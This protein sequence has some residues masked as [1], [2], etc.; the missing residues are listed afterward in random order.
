MKKI[1]VVLLLF[2]I[3]FSVSAVGTSATSAILMDQDSGR[4]LYAS[5]IH[6]VRSVASIS[7]V[8]TALLAV[9][10]GKLK[11]KV[12][13]G[14]EISGAH[15]SGIYIKKDEVLTLE[16]LVYGLMLRSGNDASLAIAHYV[17]GSVDNFVNQMN[18]KAV[19]LG[20][21]DTTFYNPN[22]LDDEEEGNYSTAYDMAILMSRAM[23]NPDFARIVGT[24]KYKLKTNMNTYIWYN[25][26]KLLNQYSY[27]TGGKTGFTKKARRTLV[28]SASKDNL[29]LVAVTLNDGNDFEDHKNL[30][31]Y[32]FANY[33]NYQILKEG[34]IEVEE[35]YYKNYKVYIKNNLSYPLQDSEK[36]T[37]HIKYQFIKN[38]TIKEETEI[39]KIQVY[40][41]DQIVKEEPI[42]A[43]LKEKPNKK[44][45]FFTKIKEWF[46][47]LW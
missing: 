11:D 3:P 5:N 9:E 28:T 8:M 46:K 24:K 29:N 36:E 41:G 33:Q 25:K 7:K 19:E 42:Y 32:G 43:D 2:C 21:K 47:N 10:S 15:G 38:K 45:G 20:M 39:G 13:I 4:I 14:D 6:D 26:N 27:T 12:T 17:S 31:E 34:I 1:I 30:F 23:Q 18:A 16:D 22:G 44:R 40:L 35:E 37:L